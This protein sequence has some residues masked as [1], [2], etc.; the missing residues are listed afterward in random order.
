MVSSWD[1]NH[2]QLEAE[3]H[4]SYCVALDKLRQDGIIDDYQRDE[5]YG[6][7]PRILL[8][9]SVVG[10]LRKKLFPEDPATGRG[11]K[12]VCVRLLTDDTDTDTVTELDTVEEEV[13]EVVDDE[14]DTILIN[15]SRSCHND[16]GCEDCD[17]DEQ[18]GS[19]DC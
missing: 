10:W 11:G 9:S 19:H 4:T 12:H 8:N 18:R 17:C 2:E 1:F 16:E 5:A 7:A 14:D 13:L 6:Y 3:L 15:K